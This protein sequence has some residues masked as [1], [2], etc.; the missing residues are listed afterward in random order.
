MEKVFDVGFTFEIEYLELLL[1]FISLSAL[2][3][4]SGGYTPNLEGFDRSMSPCFLPSKMYIIL[5]G[6]SY[7]LLPTT[8]GFLTGSNLITFDSE[9]SSATL[10]FSE[11]DKTKTSNIKCKYFIDTKI[12]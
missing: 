5:S 4:I 1:F 7:F 9:K 12:I 3:L 2:S 11:H 8:I 6:P 10:A